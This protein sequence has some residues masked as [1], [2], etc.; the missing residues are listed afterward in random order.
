MTRRNSPDV[1]V[2]TDTDSPSGSSHRRNPLQGNGHASDSAE[3]RSRI[4]AARVQ[5]A[6][7]TSTEPPST[8][9]T[10]EQLQEQYPDRDYMDESLPDGWYRDSRGKVHDEDG[11]FAPDPN[12]PEVTHNR[13]TE[14]PSTY[15]QKTH[16]EMVAKG[17]DEGKD[18][19]ANGYT[20]TPEGV[21]VDSSGNRVPRD[22][23]TWRDEDGTEIDFYD[24]NGKTNLTYDHHPPVV[25]HWIE[26][27][28]NQT[29]Q[30]RR[31]WYNKTDDMTPMSRSDNSRHGA[32][33][34]ERYSQ[35]TPGENYT[36]RRD[37]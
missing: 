13:D 23:L 3:T 30:E 8:R 24:E 20:M 28:H 17:T 32:S 26:H 31:D 37:R 27:G 15:D 19:A 12:A 14:Y 18:P 36:S 4:D 6:S 16:D 22:S 29:Y 11:D 10:R 5:N 33:L 1:D 2:D 34:E 9:P 25:Q 7:T 21:L 35:A